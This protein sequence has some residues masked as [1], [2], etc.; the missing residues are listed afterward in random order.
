MSSKD[1]TRNAC[2]HAIAVASRLALVLPAG[3]KTTV[4]VDGAAEPPLPPPPL[5]LLLHPDPNASTTAS[6]ASSRGRREGTRASWLVR[7]AAAERDWGLVEAF[8]RCQDE[9]GAGL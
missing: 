6:A 5:L 9:A 8:V 1:P 3:G 7:S 4:L 2:A